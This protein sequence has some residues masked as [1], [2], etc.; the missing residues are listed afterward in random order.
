M[1]I[2]LQITGDGIVRFS[3]G[4][5]ALA[6]EPKAKSAYRMALNDTNRAV[7]TRVKRDLATQMGTT[8]S[9]VVKHGNVRKINA[10]NGMLE[11]KIVSKGGYMPLSDFK[12]R[13]TGKGVSASPWG[14]RRIFPKTFIVSKLGG[15][16][17][18]RVGTKRLPIEKLWGPA[19]PREMV[20]DLSQKAFE[21]VARAKLPS[22]IERQLRR[23]TGGMI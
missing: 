1:A 11:A 3:A 10:S 6:S 8:Q 2:S 7:Y 18:K 15:N 19:V 23:L 14:N 12:A 21:E 13:Q 4:L 20:R 5:E 16:A 22:E 9:K 17:F